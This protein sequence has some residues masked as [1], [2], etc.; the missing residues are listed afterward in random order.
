MGLANIGKRP[1]LRYLCFFN[2]FSGFTRFFPVSQF[3]VTFCSGFPVFPWIL[4]IESIEEGF[5]GIL[6][7]G[8]CSGDTI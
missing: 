6:F 1:S 5:A 2:V 3:A 8:H 7:I 4:H